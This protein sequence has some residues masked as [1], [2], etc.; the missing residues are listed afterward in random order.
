[1]VSRRITRTIAVGL[2][3]LAPNVYASSMKMPPPDEQRNVDST[4]TMRRALP[5]R[6]HEIRTIDGWANNRDQPNWGQANNP[7]VRLCSVAYDDGA[8]DPSGLDRPSAREVSNAVCTQTE[9][10]PNDRGFSDFIWQW[11][12]FLDHDITAVGTAV[13]IEAFDIAVPTGDLYFD[14][15]GTGNETIPLNRSA[16]EMVDGIRQQMNSITSFIDASNVYGCD[17]ER[18][19]ALRTLD[20]TGR[21]RTSEGNLLPFNDAGLDNAPSALAPNYF[22]AGD[23][24]ANEQLG[25]IAMHTLFVREHNHWAARMVEMDERARQAWPADSEMP[26]PPPLTGDEIYEMAR[27]V[28]AA[29]M[30]VITYHEFL[31]LLLGPQALP[32]Y[33]GYDSTIEPG[34]ANEFAAASYRLGHT[35]LSPT[36]KRVGADGNT[37]AEGDISLADS[38]FNPDEIIATGIEPVLRGLASQRAQSLDP[39]LIDEVRNFLFGPPGSGGFDLAALNIQRGRDHGLPDYNQLRADYGLPRV[40]EFSDISSDP[41]IQQR[42]ASVYASVDEIDPW[43]GML[44]EDLVP[45][46]WVGETLMVALSEQFGVL[47]DGDRFWYQN[48]LPPAW[49]RIVERQRLADVIR[50]NTD[51]GD[52]LSDRVFKVGEAPSPPPQDNPPPPNEGPQQ[53]PQDDPQ[54]PPPPPDDNQ[55]PPPP[56]GDGGPADGNPQQPPQDGPPPPPLMSR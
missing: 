1:M 45:E 3:A 24:R 8:D 5:L 53:P 30:Q 37:I 27:A 20:G 39:Y 2:I 25:L 49:V 55:Q 13:P 21:L 4:E 32:P 16:Y 19:Y 35:M 28:V 11:G 48:S 6:L 38:F 33:R 15:T 52:E 46:A 54:A 51:I 12:Q 22:L 31:P 14:P 9:S 26:P 41:E 36:L 7:L 17:D 47:R 43:I 44:S 50:R 40:T 29:E 10:M 56:P 42:L 18:A 23:V 34:I